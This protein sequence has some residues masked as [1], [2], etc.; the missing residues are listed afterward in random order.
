MPRI[1]TLA[2]SDASQPAPQPTV[3]HRAQGRRRQVLLLVLALLPAAAVLPASV[4]WAATPSTDDLP[5]RV[6]SLAR[7]EHGTVLAPDA[8]P[9]LLARALVDTE[10]ERFYQDLGIDVVGL[11]RAAVYDVAHLCEC[12]GGSTIP[13]QLAKEVYLGGS[14][15]GLAKVAELTLALKLS[16][17]YPKA[18]VLADYAS[19][20]PTGVGRFG[21]A[22]AACADF[23]LPLAS[24]DLGEV[25]L[26]AGLP[27][28][29]SVYDP[30]VDPDAAW[31]RRQEVLASMVSD[32]D[33]TD[34]QAARAAAEP[35]TLPPA[36]GGC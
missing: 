16:L 34:S 22:S 1:K 10:D 35:V 17:W 13:G 2:R 30:L 19:V 36:P 14:D 3:P 5:S 6:A 20:V 4:A 8:V 11:G 15:A 31:A 18:Q 25:A 24:L 32:G 28:A 12:Q 26:L 21:M 27:Q 29:P 9:P 7:A 23:H 33:I